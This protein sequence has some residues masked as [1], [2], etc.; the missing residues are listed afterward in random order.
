MPSL[1]VALPA[2]VPCPS[3]SSPDVVVAPALIP[4]LSAS[5]L[6][7]RRCCRRHLSLARQ[8]LPSP[9]VFVAA[10]TTDGSGRARQINAVRRRPHHH[11]A[12]LAVPLTS[13]VQRHHNHCCHQA[14]FAAAAATKSRAFWA[15]YF[16]TYRGISPP[17]S[18]KQKSS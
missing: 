9:A 5:A 16:F 7:C 6:A 14:L 15:K 10:T 13:V 3:L 1:F 18:K 12:A 17:G 2:L 8:R 11:A 4:C